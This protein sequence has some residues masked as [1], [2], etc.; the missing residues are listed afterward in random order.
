MTAAWRQQNHLVW[1]ASGAH[2][3]ACT[4]RCRA[5]PT[6]RGHSTGTFSR[7]APPRRKGLRMPP[8]D[9]KHKSWDAT[10]WSLWGLL[11]TG[12]ASDRALQ[13]ALSQRCDAAVDLLGQLGPQAERMRSRVEE[14][15]G[16]AASYG[17]T[18][19]FG[20][21]NGAL[22]RLSAIVLEIRAQLER[23]RAL[24]TSG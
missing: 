14:W 5:G 3:F 2:T 15:K 6:P 12:A 11:Y 23:D 4:G 8:P 10:G 21:A 1:P 17:R 7:A 9:L 13:T 24:A 18:I 16:E 20:A 19:N 22:G